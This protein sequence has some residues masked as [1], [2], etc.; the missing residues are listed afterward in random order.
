MVLR[1]VVSI[2]PRGTR[3]VSDAGTFAGW[4]G[5]YFQ[6]T[7]PRTFYGPTAGGMGYAVPAAIGAKLEAPE[8]LVIGF[9]G[10]GGMAM[11]MSELETASRLRLG[12]LVYIVFNNS[13]YGTIARHQEAARYTTPV[14]VN[15]GQ[16]DFALT[17][18][19]LGAIGVRIDGGNQ[20]ADAFA[21]AIKADRP[22]VLDVVL[23]SSPLLDPWG[24]WS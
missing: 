3:V 21:E 6:W 14:G 4:M 24:D 15:L 12:G 19:S 16:V 20:F 7:E 2:S 10:D 9:A 22:A 13:C 8:C 1:D 11:T 23:P 18:Q 17:A 5:R